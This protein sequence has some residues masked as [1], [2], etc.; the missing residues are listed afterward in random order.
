MRILK[1]ALLTIAAGTIFAVIGPPIASGQEPPI[2]EDCF[3]GNGPPETVDGQPCRPP[4]PT[5]TASEKALIEAKVAKA[6]AYAAFKRGEI[7]KQQLDAV[8]QRF[9][10]LSGEEP[11]EPEEN[12]IARGLGHDPTVSGSGTMSLMGDLASFYPFEQYYNWQCGPAT[13]QSIL[14]IKSSHTSSYA[15]DGSSITGDR[16]NDQW[17]LGYSYYTDANNQGQTWWYPRRMAPTLNRWRTGFDTGFYITG[18]IAS[19]GGDINNLTKSQTMG[20][21]EDDID[22]DYPV[23]QNV[24][25]STSTY[26]TNASF[27]PGTVWEHW[28]TVYG[29]FDSGGVRYVQIGQVWGST[30]YYNVPWNTHWPAISNQHGIVW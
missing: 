18:A 5:H 19:S 28:D 6:D 29:Y 27:T 22:F 20:Y 3:V 7:S 1:T 24:E 12:R 26:L 4:N 21:I 16:L 13:A 30:L 15:P 2:D 8:S 10:E 9:W 25:Y 14:W 11:V 17:I 23:A